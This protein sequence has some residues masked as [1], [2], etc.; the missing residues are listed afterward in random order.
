MKLDHDQIVILGL[1]LTVLF[2]MV[3]LG[4]YGIAAMN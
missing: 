3:L 2:F 4:L 1:G